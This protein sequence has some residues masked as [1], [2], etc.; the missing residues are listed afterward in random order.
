MSEKFDL[1]THIRDPKTG[2]VTVAQPY[3]LHLSAEASLYERPPGSGMIYTADGQLTKESKELQAK[4]AKEAAI[5]ADIEKRVAAEVEAEFSK[6]T[7]AAPTNK[8]EA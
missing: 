3:T 5:R 6:K 4:K 8:K 2:R 7:A 1:R